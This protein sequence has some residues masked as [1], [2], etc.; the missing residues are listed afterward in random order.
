MSSQLTQ[1]LTATV[2]GVDAVPVNVEVLTRRGGSIFSCNIIG[3]GDAAVKEARERVQGAASSV[4]VDLPER[5]LINLYPAELRK[6]GSGFDLAIAAGLLVSSGRVPAKDFL[7]IA[8]FGELSL[9]GDVLPVR[10]TLALAACAAAAGACAVVVPRANVS[11]AILACNCPVFEVSHIRELLNLS[12]LSPVHFGDHNPA[13]SDNNGQTLQ[14]D[15]FDDVVGQERAKRALTVAAAGGHNVLLIGPPG[16]GK[17]MLAERMAKLLPSLTADELLEVVRVHSLAGQPV[18]GL[19]LG[20]RPFRAPHYASTG[21]GFLGGG[22]PFTPGEISLAHRGVLFLDEFPEFKRNLLEALRVP[23][24]QGTL[25]VSRAQGSL[26]LPASF[27][28]IAAMNPCPCGK[29]GS[30]QRCE[31]SIGARANYLARLSQ[32]I[33]DRIDMHVELQ[34]VSVGELARASGKTVSVSKS[35][36]PALQ[37]AEL[38]RVA[39]ALALKLRGKPNAALS[40]EELRVCAPI[41]EEAAKLFELAAEKFGLS[42]RGMT[43]VMRVARTIADLAS[44]DR[45]CTAHIAEALSYRTLERH[46]I[47]K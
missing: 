20:K 31:C 1:T 19:L 22:Q 27:Q 17:T 34:G 26:L 29:L 3:L 36:T 28:L 42:A 6:E 4:G 32:P 10:G 2:N 24:E 9:H 30:I 46:K 35:E 18:K 7:G 13:M 14:L 21:P 45:V 39:R 25:S 12:A 8:F 41:S 11:E 47:L 40:G 44:E 38:A 23:L 15:P 37:R 33:L 43:R 5:I 16:C